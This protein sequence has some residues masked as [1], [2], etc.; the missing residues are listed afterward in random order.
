MRIARKQMQNDNEPGIFS[1]LAFL[2]IIFFIVL[3]VFNAKYMFQL[4][5]PVSKYSDDTSSIIEIILP[6]NNTA[7][8]KEETIFLDQLGSFF[9][10]EHFPTQSVIKLHIAATCPYQQAVTFLDF[11]GNAGITSVNIELS[12]NNDEISQAK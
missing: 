2:L 12:D 1:D 4:H 3:A 5:F 9:N 10:K 6:G 11:A 8:Y 7:I